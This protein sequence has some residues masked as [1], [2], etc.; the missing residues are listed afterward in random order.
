LLGLLLARVGRRNVFRK[1]SLRKLN[2]SMKRNNLQKRRLSAEVIRADGPE[3]D[4]EHEP[5][6]VAALPA[7]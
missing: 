5:V 6:F 3:Q 2:M 7:C 4:A 1:R